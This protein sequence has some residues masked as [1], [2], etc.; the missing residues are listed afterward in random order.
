[1]RSLLC[2]RPP[3]LT[4]ENI[5]AQRAYE[6][7][8][9]NKVVPDKELMPT[10]RAMAEKI[11]GYPPMA[12]RMTKQTLMKTTEVSREATIL[13]TYLFK[14]SATSDAVAKGMKAWADTAKKPLH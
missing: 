11:A 8:L 5:T 13:E 1:V 9:V 14:E 3:A 4:C 12:V 10:T 6:L 7:G 2:Q